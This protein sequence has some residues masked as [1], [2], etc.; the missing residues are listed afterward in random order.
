MKENQKVCS[1]DEMDNIIEVVN[2]EDVLDKGYNFRVA[3][4]LIFNPRGDLLMQS[5]PEN[6]RFPYT[7]GSSSATYVME[8]EEYS[9]AAVRSLEK[10]LGVHLSDLGEMHK[11][12]MQDQDSKKFIG[13]YVINYDGKTD[14][15]ISEAR[16]AGYVPMNL[17]ERMMVNDKEKF[18]PTFLH[19]WNNYK[20][21]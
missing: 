12:C 20:D 15:S 5:L 9:D 11:I 10:E 14:R 4:T 3:H 13:F 19:V 2:R 6:A 18:T 7:W 8:G 21:Q 16:T 17:L 1:V